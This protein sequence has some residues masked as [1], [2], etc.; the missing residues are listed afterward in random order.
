MKKGQTIYIE[1]YNSND[2]PAVCNISTFPLSSGGFF[3]DTSKISGNKLESQV[4]DESF[5]NNWEYR[6]DNDY[7]VA[8][9]VKSSNEYD[10]L[11]GS[12]CKVDGYNAYPQRMGYNPYLWFLNPGQTLQIQNLY[13]KK[14]CV[15]PLLPFDKEIGMD[16]VQLWEGGPFWATRNMGANGEEEEGE[17]F[18]Y[19]SLVGYKWI[20]SLWQGNGTYDFSFSE[21]VLPKKSTNPYAYNAQELIDMGWIKQTY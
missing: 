11:D 21:Q 12:F 9:G 1:K 2:N 8:I 3:I 5:R 6:N 15:F 18:Q 7:P 10:W 20:N 17:F 14:Y 19:G 13:V 4:V 16:Y